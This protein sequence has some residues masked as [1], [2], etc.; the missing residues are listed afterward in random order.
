MCTCRSPISLRRNSVLSFFAKYIC[1]TADKC[2]EKSLVVNLS[3]Q[4]DSADVIT[5]DVRLTV[6]DKNYLHGQGFETTYLKSDSLFRE[7]RTQRS[8]VWTFYVSIRSHGLAPRRRF[9]GQEICIGDSTFQKTKKTKRTIIVFDSWFVSLNTQDNSV[10]I[11]GTGR[12][13]LAR[14]KLNLC[15]PKCLSPNVR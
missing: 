11:P 9:A 7:S 15:V 1:R 3:L 14:R 10:W 12:R 6:R 5:T 13:K 8:N 4:S 2:P